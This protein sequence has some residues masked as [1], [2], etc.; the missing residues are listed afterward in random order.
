METGAIVAIGVISAVVLIALLIGATYLVRKR[1][2]SEELKKL[3]G[4]LS[5]YQGFEVVQVSS[6]YTHASFVAAPA[7]G[8]SSDFVIPKKRNKKNS[9]AEYKRSSMHEVI[10]PSTLDPLLYSADQDGHEYSAASSGLN[11]P[12]VLL[13][14]EHDKLTS[15]LTVLVSQ[16]NELKGMDFE[17][18][19]NP[20]CLVSVSPGYPPEKS[21]ILRRTVSPSFNE[22]FSFKIPENEL[23]EKVIQIQFFN[24]NFLTTDE[25]LGVVEQ[26][27]SELFIDER[28]TFEIWKR[29]LPQ[30]IDHVKLPSEHLG[31]ILLRL[32][33]LPAMQR[34][35]VVVLRVRSLKQLSNK[36]GQLYAP[37][38]YVRVSAMQDGHLLKKKKTI[39]RTNNCNPIY[40]QAIY[41]DIPLD[42]LPQMEIQVHIVHNSKIKGEKPILGCIEIGPHSVGEEFEHWKDLMSKNPNARWHRLTLDPAAT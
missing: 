22:K 23:R 13:T 1:W 11:G 4:K 26:H 6:P 3:Q 40:N 16:A 10:D 38:P 29:I 5:D 36:N 27:M 34:L 18:S 25:C 35:T 7:P 30:G 41:F 42:A 20:Y 14:V 24:S 12:H 19:T 32:G 8:Q 37:D 15:L 9:K 31:D 17:E 39:T 21:A 28:D 33:Y 2:K